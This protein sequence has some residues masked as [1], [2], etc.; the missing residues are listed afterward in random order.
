MASISVLVNQ[1]L[2][3]EMTNGQLLFQDLVHLILDY[4]IRV[5]LTVLKEYFRVRT[6]ITYTWYIES[7][8]ED[9]ESKIRTNNVYII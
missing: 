2:R 1:I 7:A 3:L 8:G 6:R 4:S 9:I 5:N